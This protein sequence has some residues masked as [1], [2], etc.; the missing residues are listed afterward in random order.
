MLYTPV[1][2]TPLYF[3][4]V[5][6]GRMLDDVDLAD[7]HGQG[8]FNFRH[9]ALSRDDSKR[10]LDWAFRRDFERNGP[11]L[12]RVCRTTFEGW[13]RY[14]NHPDPRVRD[15]FDWEA[16]SLR[17]IYSALLWAMEH[18]LKKTNPAVSRQIRALRQEIAA[19]FGWVSRAAA[20]LGGPYLLWSTI[21]E[22]G[23]L[24]RGVTY[25]PESVLERRN[26]GSLEERPGTESVRT[27]P[28]AREAS[29]ECSSAGD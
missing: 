22:E 4:M 12:Y 26:W 2:G 28:P 21:R 25:E 9:A 15:R 20:A 14:R 5:S 1:P 11:S 24:A 8:K 17:T 3:Q 29:A 16:R 6:E 27:Q 13:K 10:W 23:R 7:I 19:E 18:R